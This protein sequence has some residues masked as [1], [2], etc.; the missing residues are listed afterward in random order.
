MTLN[1]SSVESFLSS[2]FPKWDAIRSVRGS[3]GRQ[4]V[5]NPNPSRMLELTERHKHL[6]C[7]ECWA[8]C[9]CW[10]SL[11]KSLLCSTASLA[12]IKMENNHPVPPIEIQSELRKTLK[13]PAIFAKL[14]W[15]WSLQGSSCPSPGTSAFGMTLARSISGI[16]N[17]K[18]NCL[19]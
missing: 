1:K 19:F 18:L 8:V 14:S 2:L 7:S 5:N 3:L 11:E 13:K 15:E 6:K 17:A 4:G 10:A 9:L 12:G 16:L